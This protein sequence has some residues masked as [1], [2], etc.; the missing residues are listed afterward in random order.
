MNY[1]HLA[2][3]PAPRP[4][5]RHVGF[6]LS[7]GALLLLA[8]PPL[9]VAADDVPQ[10]NAP[11]GLGQ[12]ESSKH[13]VFYY[14]KRELVA[15]QIELYKQFADGA[16]DMMADIWGYPLPQPEPLS[17]VT[18]MNQFV[19]YVPAAKDDT[20]IY[21]GVDRNG[22]YIAVP[23][24]A[25][26]KA[27]ELRADLRRLLTREMVTEMSG[28]NLPPGLVDGL[29][30][31]AE[32][33][34]G[35]IAALTATLGQQATSDRVQAWATLLNSAD[36]VAAPQ[37][38]S[39]AA[40]LIDGYGFRAVRTFVQSL[41][42]KRDWRTGMQDA[43]KETPATLESKWR[44]YVPQFVSNGGWQHNQFAF[45][46][47]TDAVTAVGMGQYTQAV[48]LLTPAIPFLQQIGNTKRASDAQALLSKAR[49]GAEA[50]TSVRDAEQA[51]EGNDYA[52]TNQLLAQAT[53][54]YKAIPDAKPPLLLIQYRDRA[55]RG[56][57]ATDDLTTAENAVTGWNV[58]RARQRADHAYG[59]FTEFGNAPL[60]DRAQTVIDRANREIRYAGLGTIGVGA[61]VLLAGLTVTSLR[62]GRR[63]PALPPL[64]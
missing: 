59:I 35:D 53:D 44:A 55:T 36:T 34:P 1:S 38:Y 41:A 43:F 31:Y 27:P 14:A 16:F 26:L 60:A 24:M 40:F 20:G 10:L 49:A 7:L 6:W 58:I 2:A 22:I 19:Q 63:L 46:D 5:S 50:E 17:F 9:A 39:V 30:R 32:A 52:R 15:P 13:F 57:Q 33:P 42:M 62:R 12:S 51:L 29:S 3:S 28:G 37:N 18:D 21:S 4:R 54:L 45:Y 25:A 8:L 56:L 11:V 23:R 61:F 47:T 64:E 48:A